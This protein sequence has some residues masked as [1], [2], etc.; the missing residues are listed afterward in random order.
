MSTIV[1]AGPVLV[2]LRATD[3]EHQ[4]NVD[5]MLSRIPEAVFLTMSVEEDGVVWNGLVER[6]GGG[7]EWKDI[8]ELG[9]KTASLKVIK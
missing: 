4:D 5:T 8:T 6:E 7:F 1:N 3:P 2:F 9:R